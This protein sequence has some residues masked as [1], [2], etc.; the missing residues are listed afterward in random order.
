MADGGVDLWDRSPSEGRSCERADGGGG[1]VVSKP[2]EDGDE[3]CQWD[4]QV[5]EAARVVKVADGHGQ[6][7]EGVRGLTVYGRKL[8]QGSR[9]V[10]LDQFIAAVLSD[11][12]P[13]PMRVVRGDAVDIAV[14][15]AA[16]EE[17]IPE[18]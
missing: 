2:V 14:N 4:A 10:R 13:P 15:K 9:K 8:R 5:G 6:V 18:H 16:C 17:R 11:R 7:V 3:D 12:Q 1:F